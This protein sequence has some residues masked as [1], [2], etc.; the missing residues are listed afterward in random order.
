MKYAN[1]MCKEFETELVSTR[2][3]LWRKETKDFVTLEL[4]KRVINGRNLHKIFSKMKIPS[5]LF[6]AF[7]YASRL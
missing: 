1:C 7:D 2:G 5:M 6:Q 3:F 4:N